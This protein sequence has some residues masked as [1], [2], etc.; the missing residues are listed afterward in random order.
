MSTDHSA[1]L[2]D[3]RRGRNE[4]PLPPLAILVFNPEDLASYSS[5]FS[6]PLNRSHKLYLSEVFTGEYEG[7]GIA[8]A[9]PMLGAPQTILVLEK[10]IALGTRRFIA[11]GWCGSLQEVVRIGEIVL[12]TA[13]I[14]DE[15]TSP[16]YPGPA[17]TPSPP[18]FGSLKSTLAASGLTTHE[19]TVWTTDAPF[20]ETFDKVKGFQANGVL[21]VDME[22]SALFTVAHFRGVDAAAVLVVSDD[23]SGLKWVHGFRDPAFKEARKRVIKT[24]LT[25]VMRVRIDE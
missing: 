7:A 22:T 17:P 2:I 4:H 5:C 13:A 15:G 23:L 9:G 25:A 11:T 10:M 21:A 3:P 14:C 19:G 20:R 12:P 1:C 24:T 18:L 16:H 6:K 8:V